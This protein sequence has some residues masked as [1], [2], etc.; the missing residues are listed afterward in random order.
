MREEGWAEE[1]GAARPRAGGGEEV[2]RSDRREQEDEESETHRLSCRAAQTNF[3]FMLYFCI[4]WTQ[5][6]EFKTVIF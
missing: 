5:T 3:I 1:A 2:N 6:G 4:F